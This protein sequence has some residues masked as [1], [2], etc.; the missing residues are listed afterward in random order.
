MLDYKLT[1]QY[2]V[3]EKI[4]KA[5]EGIGLLRKLVYFTPNIFT[6]YLQIVYKTTFGPR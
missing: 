5:I 1:F 2:H 4:K 3:N 6:N